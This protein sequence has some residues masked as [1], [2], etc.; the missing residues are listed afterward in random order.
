[1]NEHDVEKDLDGK[2]YSVVAEHLNN[3]RKDRKDDHTEYSVLH[4]NDVKD[5]ANVL[6]DVMKPGA[7]GGVF[8]YTLQFPSVQK[9]FLGI[10]RKCEPVPGK[11]PASVGL[12]ERVLSYGRPSR[13]GALHRTIIVQVETINIQ[14]PQSVQHTRV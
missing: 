1:M 9:L 7:H 4:S 11:I 13:W 6:G 5:L 3:L 8:C 10:K 12:K 2:L 14:P